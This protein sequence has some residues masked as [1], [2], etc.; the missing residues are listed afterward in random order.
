M[1]DILE[2]IDLDEDIQYFWPP[3][4]REMA[5]S[6]RLI[7][8]MEQFGGPEAFEVFSAPIFGR[9]G[10]VEWPTVSRVEVAH[11][12]NE[13][14]GLIVWESGVPSGHPD[15]VYPQA[16]AGW[17]DCDSPD[18]A[19]QLQQEKLRHDGI[20]PISGVTKYFEDGVWQ[21]RVLGFDV[22]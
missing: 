18:Q 17:P 2:V 21:F 13:R 16:I 12:Q 19:L 20:P 3:L 1:V 22:R 6:P 14:V 7:D 4:E 11:D 5:P 15:D 10:D 8:L 9:Q